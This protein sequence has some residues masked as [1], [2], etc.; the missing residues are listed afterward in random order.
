MKYD[1]EKKYEGA[2]ID[3][4]GN[5]SDEAFHAEMLA[6]DEGNAA[7]LETAV[8]VA[9]RAG[10][11]EY[12][13]RSL[14]QEDQATELGDMEQSSLIAL[15][16]SAIRER[17]IDFILQEEFSQGTRFLQSFLKICGVEEIVT[18]VLEVLASV[19]DQ[20]G[21]TDVLVSYRA[22]NDPA[23]SRR[24][25][26]IE[27]K[28][29][30]AFQPDQATRYTNRGIQGVANRL[31]NSYRTCL[32]APRAYIQSKHG[33]QH[34]VA[35]EEVLPL[36]A[37]DSEERRGFKQ[38]VLQA[39]IEEQARQ[40]LRTEDIQMTEFRSSYYEAFQGF[41]AQ[42][43]S[44]AQS[45]RNIDAPLPRRA[46]WGDTW[47]EFRGPAIKHRVYINHKSEAGFVDLT[48][49]NTD[50]STLQGAV[51]L[52]SGMSF[53]QTGNSA[54]IRL[55]T[56]PLDNHAPF[57]S[58]VEALHTAFRAVLKLVTFYTDHPKLAA[59]V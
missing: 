12:K 43:E 13:A 48:F 24:V 19:R 32:V 27:N 8:R 51:T 54:A 18:D 9:V 47:Y 59:A 42:A 44:A 40:G 3:S 4:E 7:S 30:A 6:S 11:P 31:W 17:Q 49:R 1:P 45:V 46:W 53:Q 38:K 29:D 50:I 14:M 20:H 22:E 15:G 58:Q 34:S 5:I 57:A 36:L 21:E 39:A 28:L 16:Q 26:L 35:L 33:F 2:I 10:I 41:R 25:L 55:T 23:S 56:P 52:E 37:P